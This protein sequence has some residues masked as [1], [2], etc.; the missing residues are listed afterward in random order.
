MFWGWWGGSVEVLGDVVDEYDEIFRVELMNPQHALLGLGE[1]TIVDDDE[2]LVRIDDVEIDES[3]AGTS[4]ALFTVALTTP[5]EREVSV[6]YVTVAETA[7]AG[8]DYVTASGTLVFAAGTTAQTVAVEIVGDVI[9]ESD[10]TFRVELSAAVNAT[11]DDEVGW[12]T[13]LDDEVCP[14]PNLL[15]NPGAEAAG[16]LPGWIQAAGDWQRRPAPPDPVEGE[17]MFFAGASGEAELYQDV[18]IGAY[19]SRIAAGDQA[20]AF[21]GWLR[22]ADEVPSDIARIV[23]EYRDAGNSVVL[24]LFDSGEIVGPF[25]WQQVSDVRAAPVGTVWIRVRL[26]ASRFAGED[27]DASFDALALRSLRAPVLAVDDVAVSEGDAGTTD[28]IFTVSLSCAYEEAVDVS[29]QTA[30]GTALAGD[31]YLVSTGG[32]SFPVGATAQ[33]IAVPVV[34][35][36]TDEPQ[37]SFLVE[38][39]DLS[40]AGDVVLPAGTAGIGTIDDDDA[41]PE[42]S[43]S[44]VTV[45]E[46]ESEAIFSVELSAASGFDVTVDYATAEAT[47]T[48][49]L[50]YESASGE[51]SLPAGTTSRT[52]AVPILDD[53]LDEDDET[54]L[55]ALANAEHAVLPAA[56]GVGTIVDDDL[57]PTLSI[58]D[59]AVTEGT[60]ADTSAVFTLELSG[61]SGREI[62][63]SYGTANGSAVAAQDYQA[64]SGIAVFPAGT[65]MQT[66]TVAVAGDARDEDDEIFAVLLSNPVNVE[67]A[68]GEAVGVIVDDDEPPVLSVSSVTVTEGPSVQAVFTVALSAQSG[69]DVTVG[70]AT[71]DGTATASLDYQPASGELSFPAGTT[72]RTVAVAIADDSLDEEHETFLL[73][74]ANAVHA[75]LPAGSGVGTIVD[76]DEPPEIS[77]RDVTVTEGDTGPVE[78]VFI[79]SLSVASG[80]EVTV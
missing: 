18:D 41:A 75:V 58:L 35:D 28:A 47:A 49:G 42:L 7:T 37:E 68:R 44:S 78:A 19:A 67:V 17:A 38:L 70:Y 73:T 14:G 64:T 9:L 29:Y 4:E 33:T 20:F 76:D 2:A 52:V 11:I 53:L 12:G 72:S 57:A 46:T 43:V 50:D 26:L 80:R 27:N 30:D 59:A 22:T 8:D 48:A 24:D 13:I 60:G 3:D 71:A 1:G 32:L 16:G 56:A 51:L 69:F 77:V 25:G 10:E 21:D 15:R 39:V 55:L 65:T 62:R 61:A 40:S 5:S 34:G 23:V 6:E 63:V 45:D 74:L 54:F 36:G 79:V 31:D 66:V